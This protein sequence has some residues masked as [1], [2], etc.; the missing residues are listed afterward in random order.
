[1]PPDLPRLGHLPRYNQFP[2]CVHPQ[3]LTLR[4]PWTVPVKRLKH[5]RDSYGM[6]HGLHIGSH[7]LLANGGLSLNWT[8]T[9]IGWFLVTWPWLKSNVSR[10]WY[11]KQCTLFGIYYN[12]RWKV[13]WQKAGKTLSVFFFVN[14]H[15]NTNMKPQAKKQRF[16]KLSQKRNS[17]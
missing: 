11:I 12:T 16:S 9:A 6:S 7:Q 1:M 17:S 14:E 15:N 2:S 13:A 10:S 4:R 8:G 5:F 3:N